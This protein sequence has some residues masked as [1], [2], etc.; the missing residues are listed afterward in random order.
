MQCPVN[1]TYLSD[2]MLDLILKIICV[3]SSAGRVTSRSDHVYRI[4]TVAVEMKLTVV[5]IGINVIIDN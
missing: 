5:N 3:L 4:R 1:Y 2:K